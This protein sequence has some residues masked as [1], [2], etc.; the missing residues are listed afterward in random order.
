[1]AVKVG[2]IINYVPHQVHARQYDTVNREFPWVFGWKTGDRQ[3]VPGDRARGV[4]GKIVEK[5][6]ELENNQEIGLK[7]RHIRK[8]APERMKQEAAKLV[9]IRP[10]KCWQA[11]VV[12]VSEDGKT[13]DLDV[14]DPTNGGDTWENPG[15]VLHYKKVPLDETEAKSPHSCHAKPDEPKINTAPVLPPTNPSAVTPDA[16]HSAL[17]EVG[18]DPSNP[19]KPSQV[20]MCSKSWRKFVRKA[21]HLQRLVGTI[22]NAVVG[23]VKNDH[24]SLRRIR[25]AVSKMPES[26]LRRVFSGE[27]NDEVFR[28]VRAAFV[29]S[30]GA[31][32]ST[33]TG[34]MATQFGWGAGHNLTGINYNPTTNGSTI[35]KRQPYG[36]NVG[37]NTQVGGCD[38]CFSFQQGVAAGGSGTLNVNGMTDLLQAA[39]VTLARLKGYQIRLLSATD[40]STISPAPTATSV[41]LVTNNTLAT[42]SP[43]DFNNGLTG[44]TLT[45]STSTGA[46]TSATISAAG[47][48][49]PASSSFIV[50]PVEA[51]GSGATV[52]VITN[53]SGVPNTVAVLQ[54]GAGYTATTVPTVVAGAYTLYTG[55][56]HMLV[57]LNPN[58]FCT[59]SATNKNVDLINQDATN[60]VTFEV[61]IFGA[62]T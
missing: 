57:D 47:S 19:P 28:H 14:L 27:K 13:V 33:L 62:T 39:S 2:D 55:D 42:P 44:L 48:G 7:L 22:E 58:G 37:T 26:F 23:F 53:S 25:D 10:N 1:M 21:K 5:V 54:Q 6:I 29:V 51:G 32:F 40:D 49:A 43:L 8:Q 56:A 4:Q 45:L 50:L 41:G 3:Q 9:F 12:A 24:V 35:N 38:E 59:V 11:K 34:A 52:T 46:I 61:D 20:M 30:G 16:P 60:A 17:T 15:V 36:T 18:P 31:G